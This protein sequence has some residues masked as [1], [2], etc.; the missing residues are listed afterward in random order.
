MSVRPIRISG[1]PV[2]HHRALPVM[3]WD[4]PLHELVDDLVDTMRA[5]P[6]VGL[7][8]PQI[9]VPLQVFVWGWEDTLG[10]LHEGAIINPTLQSDPLPRR[11]LDS[12]AEVEGC[13]SL[14][15]LRYPLRRADRVT[16]GGFDRD[17]KPVKIEAEGWL[18]RIFQHEGDH[19]QG[20][21]YVDRL[22][23]RTRLGARRDTRREGWGKP[24][25]SW[26]P[27]VDDFEASDHDTEE[28]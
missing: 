26:L 23:F 10:V 25:H 16:L 18:A 3:T 2:L 9:G 6:G 14:P 5:A 20:L 8:A 22:P 1:D 21:L 28:A 4:A 12:D 13:L 17:Q 19:L 7:A 24:G 11:A 27:G 15:D